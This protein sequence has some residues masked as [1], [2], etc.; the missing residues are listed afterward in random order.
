MYSYELICAMT[1]VI[2]KWEMKQIPPILIMPHKSNFV[3]LLRCHNS[4]MHDEWQ[5]I[6]DIIFQRDTEIAL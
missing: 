4:K 3:V 2:T 1:E 5:I 6:L